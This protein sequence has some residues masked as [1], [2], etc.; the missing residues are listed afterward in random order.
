[1]VQLYLPGGATYTE[2]QKMDAVATN[3]PRNRLCFHL[4]DWPQKPTHRIKQNAASFH[5]T[6]AVAHRKPKSG[7]HGKFPHLN[8]QPKR[9]LDWFSRFCTEDRS[10]R[11]LYDGTPLAPS[12]SP[13]PMGDL[14]PNL[15]HG[16]LGPP[17]S[18]AH[19]DRCSHFGGAH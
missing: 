7:C 13:L 5:T 9:H 14:D 16:S 3:I 17:K 18:S 2:S 6:E 10:V 1:M 11:I 19:I 4:R 12:K 15:I 8:Q